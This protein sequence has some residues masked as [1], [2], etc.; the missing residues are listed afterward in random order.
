VTQVFEKNLAKDTFSKAAGFLQSEA[1]AFLIPA[2]DFLPPSST[3]FE[4]QDR[5]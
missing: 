3:T 5:T 4:V 1:A 2:A